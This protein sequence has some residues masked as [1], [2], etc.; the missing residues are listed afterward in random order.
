MNNLWFQT[1]KT[2]SGFVPDP[3]PIRLYTFHHAGG[4]CQYFQPWVAKLPSWIELVSVQLPGRWN[5]VREPAFLRMEQLMPVLGAEFKALLAEN[6][7]QKYAFYGHSLGGLVAYELTKYLIRENL[8]LPVRLF[9]SS[10]RAVQVSSHKFPIYELP[11]DKFE[12]MVTGLY[13]ALPP[14]VTADPDIKAMFLDITKKDMELLDT[15]NYTPDPLINVPLTIFGGIDDHV[16][17]LDSLQG[18][19]ELTSADCEIEQFP[20]GHFFLRDSEVELLDKI[21][22]TLKPYHTP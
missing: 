2:A 17:T 20:G 3:N 21:V 4:S 16:I 15:Y 6:P 12:I 13:G 19:K 5:R 1:F 9:I 7:N 22:K 10:K 18:W 14:E 11:I 8:P